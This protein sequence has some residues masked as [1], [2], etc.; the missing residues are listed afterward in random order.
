MQEKKV[1]VANLAQ[2]QPKASRSLNHNLGISQPLFLPLHGR[3]GSEVDMQRRGRTA[4]VSWCT[5]VHSPTYLRQLPHSGFNPIYTF[6]RADL[7]EH[8]EFTSVHR[9]GLS[10]LQ[11]GWLWLPH[12]LLHTPPKICSWPREGGQQNEERAGKNISSSPNTITSFHLQKRSLGH[13]PEIVHALF[14]WVKLSSDPEK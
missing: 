4:E 2:G 6:L 3:G 8:Y 1:G 5:R 13:K 14:K 10:A 7:T 12:C 9:I 11:V